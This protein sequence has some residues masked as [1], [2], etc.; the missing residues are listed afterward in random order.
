MI[1][2]KLSQAC[3]TVRVV[4]LFLSQDTLKMI[5]YAYFH[6]IMTYGII[7]WGNS[8]Y[9]DKIFRLKKKRIIRIIMGARTRDS[10]RELFNILNILP[11]TSQYIFSF[12]LFVVNN[13]GLFTEFS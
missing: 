4:K 2:L 6:T 9:F 10:C 8:S 12:A 1:T 13:K 11:L 5:Y 3:Y 7:F